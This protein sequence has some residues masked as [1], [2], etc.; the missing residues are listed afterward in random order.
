MTNVE[1][2][3]VRFYEE[4][5]QY[6]AKEVLKPTTTSNLLSGIL[7]ELN[8]QF[9]YRPTEKSLWATVLENGKEVFRVSREA[10][11]EVTVMDLEYRETFNY[12]PSESYSL[13]CV[14]RF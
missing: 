9:N 8:H 10:K 1:T 5:Y 3:T 12:K 6:S 2:V 13:T 14:A 7:E 11:S 4:S